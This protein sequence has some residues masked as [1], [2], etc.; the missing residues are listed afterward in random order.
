MAKL[1]AIGGR[2]LAGRLDTTGGKAPVARGAGA[3]GGR[4]LTGQLDTTGGRA[5]AAR[6]AGATEGRAPG[7][8][9][10]VAAGSLVT[11]TSE[12]IW[13]G[14]H[15]CHSEL[16]RSRI[17]MIHLICVPVV[18]AAGR[19]T[20][21]SIFASGRWRGSS[22]RGRTGCRRPAGRGIPLLTD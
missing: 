15:D 22:F 19:H 13:R 5:P 12:G 14:G 3:T 18:R 9:G 1:D 4:A 17:K 20:D 11:V 6:G 8:V 21:R 16:A 7:M 10:P 2:A